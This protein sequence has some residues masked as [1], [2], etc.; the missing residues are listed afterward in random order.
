MP[1]SKKVCSVSLVMAPVKVFDVSVLANGCVPV[2]GAEMPESVI[3]I[4]ISP[5]VAL[6]TLTELLSSN[7]GRLK[8]GL[9]NPPDCVAK[10]VAPSA[11]LKDALPVP[12]ASNVTGPPML[13]DQPTL[14]VSALAP[15]MLVASPVAAARTRQN[16]VTKAPNLVTFTG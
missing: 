13:V 2:K 8:N 6:D 15:L 1:A 7:A 16:L 12:D 5:P 3:Q 11:P 4:K 14:I 9:T 10:P